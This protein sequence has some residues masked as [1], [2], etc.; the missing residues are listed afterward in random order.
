MCNIICL[1]KLYRRLDNSHSSFL[2]LSENYQTLDGH[3]Q[4]DKHEVMVSPYLQDGRTRNQLLPVI[5]A[6]SCAMLSDLFAAPSS[7]APNIRSAL[8]HGTWE[9]ELVKEL[10]GLTE[11]SVVDCPE[12]SNPLLVDAACALVSCLDLISSDLS[13][14]EKRISSY[15]PVYTFTAS[16]VRNLNAF[17]HNLAELDALISNNS[18]IGNCIRSMETLHPKL[19]E[20]L[21]P[22]KTELKVINKMACDLFPSMRKSDDKPWG[23]EDIY[24]EH[25]TNVALASNVAALTLLSDASH[26]LENYLAGLYESID[27]LS[28]EPRNTKDHRTLKTSARFCSA[29]MI[30]RDFYPWTVYVALLQVKNYLH[31]DGDD[32]ISNREDVIRATERSRMVLSTVDSY[33]KTNLDRSLKALQ[34]YIQGKVVKN[35]ILQKIKLMW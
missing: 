23:V 5:G 13:D 20:E 21:R 2:S 27:K 33:L 1:V 28:M 30:V 29:A 4:R 7:E 26:A 10:K 3:G 11:K 9:G 15:R 18:S 16:V 32:D 17:L 25:Q 31:S 12:R 35:V 6:Q 24:S 14:G 19:I 22:L 34:Q 8:F